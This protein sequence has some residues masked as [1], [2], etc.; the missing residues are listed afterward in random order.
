MGDK[1]LISDFK[2]ER[3]DTADDTLYRVV[4]IGK[5]VGVTKKNIVSY[6]QI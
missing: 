1:S 6:R 3:D 4:A 2:S 5:G